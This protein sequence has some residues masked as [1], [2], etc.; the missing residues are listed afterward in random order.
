[1]FSV[2]AAASACLA[3]YVRP[4]GYAVLLAVAGVIL[5]FFWLSSVIRG[6]ISVPLEKIQKMCEVGQIGAN[7]AILTRDDEIGALA[8]AAVAMTRELDSRL[9]AACAE[10]AKE[11]DE[12]ARRSMSE[13]ICG[14]V[15]PQL[16]PDIPSRASFE[17]NGLI[18]TGERKDCQF[19]DYFFIDPGLLCVML[20]ETPGNGVAEAMYMVVAQTTIR[21]RLRLG[22]SLEETMA[23]VNKQLYDLGSQFCLNALVATL[24]TS[25]GRFTYVNAGQ[26]RPLFMKNEDR[27]E[28]LE[29]PVYDP[30]GLNENV[31]YRAVEMK[32][33]QG[34]RLFLHTE[35]MYDLKNGSG[36][37]YGEQQLRSDLN[38]TRSRNYENDK[39]LK[40][41]DEQAHAYCGQA[42]G[43]GG[44][45]MLALL[46]CKGNKEL[47]HC[48]V[49]PR[50]EYAAE[51]TEFLKKQFS[52]NG[53]DKKHYAK[54]AVLM[55]EVFSLC[56]RRAEPDSRVMVECGVAPDGLMANL[57]VTA[58]LNGVDP[59]E[60]EGDGL[61]ENAAEFI[62]DNADYVTFKPGEERDTITIVC[63][64][65]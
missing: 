3:V 40:F 63:F 59:M 14:S 43:N 2:L 12:N 7:N 58:R 48:E 57:R 6:Q 41:M 8:S 47:A 18:V 39:L 31:S 45:A 35:G 64:L 15:L 25:D 28:W 37:P 5:T 51:V 23:D 17:V 30:L 34:D 52:D 9:E 16:L 55:D 19:Y 44:F 1:M 65:E 50:P 11:A 32:L 10:A 29:N 49:P 4:V 36:V 13:E 53:I 60:V 26:Q 46:F 20:G 62:R 21:S 54:E 61:S 24:G 27:Y 42:E 33:R 56:C 22:R 38:V